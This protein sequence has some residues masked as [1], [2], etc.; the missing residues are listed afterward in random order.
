MAGSSLEAITTGV[1]IILPL[2][3]LFTPFFVAF[4]LH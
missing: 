2:P 3:L 1:R 4:G